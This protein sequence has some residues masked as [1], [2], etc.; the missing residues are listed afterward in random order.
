MKK[1]TKVVEVV[2]DLDGSPATDQTQ[3]SPLTASMKLIRT[4]R[5]S[6]VNSLPRLSQIF[7]IAGLAVF[8]STR[9]RGNA[10]NPNQRLANAKIRGQEGRSFLIVVAFCLIVE[11][12]RKAHA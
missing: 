11:A 3:C 12:Y 1:T 10:G 9:R 4:A 7:Y 6:R 2:D 5:I 8:S